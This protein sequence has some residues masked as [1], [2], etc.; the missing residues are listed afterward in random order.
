MILI[1][2][3][4]KNKEDLRQPIIS[5]LGHVDHG[6]TSLL[7]A[8][9]GSSVALKEAGGITQRIG[10]TEISINRIMELSEGT[11]KKGI[12]KI[13]GILFV[14]TPGHVA[15]SNMR[16][17]GGALADIAILVIDINDGL[18]PQ[19]KESINILKKFRTP[20][21]V[22]ANKIDLIPYYRKTE[23]KLF[24]KF[25]KAQRDEYIQEFDKRFYNLV[26]EL[27]NEGFQAERYDRVTDFS[28]FV[29]IIPASS[30]EGIG[31]YETLLTISGLAQKYLSE[32]ISRIEGLGKAS[33]LEVRKDDSAG[34]FLDTVLYQGE[35]KK[36]SKIYVNTDAGIKETRI[37]GLFV[38]SSTRRSTIKEKELVKSAAGVRVLI[39]DS[40]N[41]IPGSTLM[42]SNGNIAEAEE[43]FAQESRVNVDLSKNGVTLKADTLGSLE[44]VA[45]ELKQKNIPIRS[46]ATGEISKRD[47]I[48]VSTLPD[49]MD[50]LIVGFN[51][52]LSPDAR[53]SVITYDCG[54]ITSNIIYSLIEETEKWLKDKKAEIE[55]EKKQ[56]FPIPSKITILPQYIFRQAKPVLVGIRVL[57]GRIKVNDTLIRQDGKYAGTIKSI[58]DGDVNRKFAD[59]GSEVSV[60]IDGVILN[61]H[62]F[63][64]EIIY[65]DITEN[66]VK[67]LRENPLDEE[68]MKTMEEIIKIKRKENIFWGSKA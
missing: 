39:S 47:L 2:A 24:S 5:V 6:K 38:N 26:N 40:Y 3:E 49:A 11:L 61:R 56:S 57:S 48:D 55:E 65:V 30:R 8:I 50:R 52:E 36:G 27:Y 44:A 64:D 19:T 4:L 63:P 32:N 66:T 42:V 14:D 62:I 23:S 46:A 29:S 41:V 10:A 33:V 60:A 13:P 25:I 59:A 7:D 15:F 34:I 20:F 51:V 53:N 16:A 37:K 58:K 68:T 17:R 67:A 31:I 1:P 43:E 21:V 28:K 9:R 45:Y 12:L 22:V 35:L 54:V 18:M